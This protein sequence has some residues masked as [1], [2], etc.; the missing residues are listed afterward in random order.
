MKNDAFLFH[1]MFTILLAAP[2]SGAA[3]L[4]MRASAVSATQIDLDPT[5]GEQLL[6]ITRIQH[7]SPW[8][9]IAIT[10]PATIIWTALF[11]IYHIH[12]A[13]RP[14]RPSLPTIYFYATS[15]PP[16]CT[17]LMLMQFEHTYN[18]GSVDEWKRYNHT[19]AVPRSKT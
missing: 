16:T 7:I 2:F 1:A 12:D 6:L 13:I 11:F 3:L 8:W 10:L 17:G 19:P 4:L 18:L 5:I 9:L 14:R 15:I